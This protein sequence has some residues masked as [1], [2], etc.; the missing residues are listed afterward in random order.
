MKSSPGF[1]PKC[2]LC[3][4]NHTAWNAACSARQKE[5]Q[6]VEKA[7]QLRNHYWPTQPRR[8]A[9]AT[10]SHNQTG[11]TPPTSSSDDTTGPETQNQLASSSSQPIREPRLLRSSRRQQQRNPIPPSTGAY[12]IHPEPTT[13]SEPTMQS[14]QTADHIPAVS[15]VVSREPSAAQSTATSPQNPPAPLSE[16][17]LEGDDWLQNLDLNWE[18][19]I[20]V[21]PTPG[22]STILDNQHH[23]G[24]LLPR[25]L[26]RLERTTTTFDNLPPPRRGCYCEEHGHLYEN[27]PIRDAELIIGTCI[28]ECPYCNFRQESPAELRKHIK[29]RHGKRNLMVR[30]GKLGKKGIIPGWNALPTTQTQ[31][32]QGTTAHTGI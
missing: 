13:Y 6:R 24:G 1:K 23:A 15:T 31:Y 3:G 32:T 8:T 5:M 14:Q 19:T 16:Y 25:E 20:A 12:I 28:R 17:F 7:K 4:G 11:P 30:K 21:G 2:A 27:W 10:D 9:S 22:L 26:A 18:D 29:G